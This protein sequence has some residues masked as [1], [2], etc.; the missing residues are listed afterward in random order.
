[1]MDSFVR[2]QL[3]SRFVRGTVVRI[4][5]DCFVSFAIMG[6]R[7]RMP[8]LVDEDSSDD[9]WSFEGRVCE[10]SSDGEESPEGLVHPCVLVRVACSSLLKM[11][12]EKTMAAYA[13]AAW[14]GEN[15]FISEE[16]READLVEVGHVC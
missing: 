12:G 5:S 14:Q 1:M 2:L 4:A 15:L 6:K 11:S 13:R 3:F 16:A 9:E 7:E 8:A 10:E